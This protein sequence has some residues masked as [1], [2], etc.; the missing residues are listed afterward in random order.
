MHISHCLYREFHFRD[1]S[2]KTIM[3]I[4]WEILA[5]Q[6]SNSEY[7]SIPHCLHLSQVEFALANSV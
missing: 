6:V 1:G 4:K 3:M 7:F 5:E 2:Q